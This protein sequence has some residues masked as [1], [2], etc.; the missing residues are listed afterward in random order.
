MVLSDAFSYLEKK[1][2]HHQHLMKLTLVP[3]VAGL[4]WERS[5]A[6]CGGSK[7][8][9]FMFLAISQGRCLSM[10][11]SYIYQLRVLQ[12][13]DN[14]ECETIVIIQFGVFAMT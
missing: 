13:F 7:M 14:F 3:C 5:V 9:M 1:H 12:E 4:R 8:A 11:S 2:L 6:R 10:A